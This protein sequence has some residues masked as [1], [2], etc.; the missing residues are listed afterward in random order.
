MS[1]ILLVRHGQASFGAANYDQLSPLGV[2]Q[3]RALGAALSAQGVA[4]AG[5]MAGAM[6]RHGQTASA[7]LEGAGW[8][9]DVTLDSA[10]DEFEVASFL[11]GGLDGAANTD[12]RAFQRVL[13][14]GIRT[15]AASDPADGAGESFT[16]FAARVEAGLQRLV[17]EPSP[18][19][20]I[21][22]TTS[23][24][25][26]SWAVTSLLGGGIEQWIR[27]NRVC[28]NAAVT[29]LINGRSGLSLVSFNEHGHLSGRDVT[30][31]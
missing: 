5:V 8:T 29:K 25:A 21:V 3:S 10:W 30:Y 31:R 12:S 18:P 7:I 23:A 4:P 17:T 2:T 13:D 15:W 16:A 19:G 6:R 20:P 14:D 26:I 11:P 24:G 28:I 1:A 27:L 22:V 9:Q